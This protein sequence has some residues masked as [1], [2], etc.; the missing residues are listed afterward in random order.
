MFLMPNTNAPLLKVQVPDPT[1]V[2]KRTP[3]K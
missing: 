1:P 3:A 2:Q